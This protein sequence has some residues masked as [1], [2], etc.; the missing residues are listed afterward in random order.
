MKTR[1]QWGK[2]KFSRCTLFT[3]RCAAKIGAPANIIRAAIPGEPAS[4]RESITC[5]DPASSACSTKCYSQ[6][7]ERNQG[8]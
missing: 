1:I 2:M 6:I 3:T 8:Q 5:D 7:G 4:T